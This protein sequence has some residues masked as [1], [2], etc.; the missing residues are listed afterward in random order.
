PPDPTRPRR[1]ARPSRSQL[2]RDGLPAPPVLGDRVAQRILDLAGAELVVVDLTELALLGEAH[3]SAGLDLV[4]LPTGPGL[5]HVG[6][7]VAPFHRRLLVDVA[8]LVVAL[9]ELQ[10]D[11]AHL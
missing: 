10:L 1:G 11:P 2:E 5:A 8:H 9:I 3:R 6:D 4:D 7:A